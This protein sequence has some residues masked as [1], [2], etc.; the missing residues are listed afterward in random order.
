MAFAVR[1]ILYRPRAGEISLNEEQVRFRGVHC[2][3]VTSKSSAL[4]EANHSEFHE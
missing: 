4:Q 1:F 3:Q 2:A